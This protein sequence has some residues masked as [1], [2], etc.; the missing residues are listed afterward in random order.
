MRVRCSAALLVLML[1]GLLSAQE[2]TIGPA[3]TMGGAAR[4][5]I[6]EGDV[7]YYGQGAN[8]GVADITDRA[9]PVVL[10]FLS[11]PHEILD[12]EIR[13]P[14]AYIYLMDNG[15]FHIVDITDPSDVRI[16]GSCSVAS[17]YS[18]KL[19]VAGNRVF[20]V[21][22]RKNVHV[23]DVEQASNP[24]VT[25]SHSFLTKDVAVSGET[26]F[27]LG[28]EYGNDTPRGLYSFDVSDPLQ[29]TALDTFE[30]ETIQF[31]EINGN[32]AFV[33]EGKDFKGLKILDISD[34]TDIRHTS[35]IRVDGSHRVL[36]IGENYA[37]MGDDNIT[38]IDISDLAN[39]RVVGN[40]QFPA[41]SGSQFIDREGSYLYLALRNGI[42]PFN[43]LDISN[44]A[45]PSEIEVFNKAPQTTIQALVQG[46]RLYI[47]SAKGFW[48]YSIAEQTNP[49]LIGF[50]EHEGRERI[51]RIA[52]HNDYVY[53]AE[54]TFEGSIA[55]VYIHSIQNPAQPTLLSSFQS[56]GAIKD[57][58]VV[59]DW[60][61][62]VFDTGDVEFYSLTDPANPSLAGHTTVDGKCRTIEISGSRAFVAHTIDDTEMRVTLFDIS[63]LNSIQELGFFNTRGY[64]EC[65]QI[66]GDSVLVG[67][68]IGD[69][70]DPLF[71]LQGKR[72]ES[73]GSWSE[74]ASLQST[75]HIMAM[76]VI[77][78]YVF[79][80]IFKGSVHVY[81]MN[82]HSFEQVGYCE[83]KGTLGLATT[84]VNANGEGTAFTPEGESYY[85]FGEKFGSKGLVIQEYKM[86]KSCC[87]ETVVLPPEAA[88][89]GC[90]ATPDRV[91]G[92]CQSEVT[93]MAKEGEEW[94]FDFWSGAA[95]GSEL[96]TTARM[97]DNCSI[98]YAH[99]KQVPIL[100]LSGAQ[101]DTAFCPD[102]PELQSGV[103]IL[104]FSLTADDLA[105]WK[106]MSIQFSGRGF[107]DDAQDIKNARLYRGKNL[108]GETQ[109]AQDDG[110]ITFSLS[111]AVTIPA[112]G[113]VTL[114]LEYQFQD[115]LTFENQTIKTFTAHTQMSWI[116]AIPIVPPFE[117]FQKTPAAPLGATGGEIIIAPVW[118]LQ[119]HLGYATINKA[120]MAEQTDNGHTILACPGTYSENVV[121]NKSLTIR[122]RDGWQETRIHAK[123]PDAHTV[124]VEADSCTIDGF[125]M[126]GATKEHMAGCKFV[127]EGIQTGVIKNCM[128]TNNAIGLAI[129]DG[130]INVET[131]T[132]SE[133][134]QHGIQ[135]A[136]NL[137]DDGPVSIKSSFMIQNLGNGLEGTGEEIS[138]E[139]CVI[140]G[141]AKSGAIVTGTIAFTDCVIDSNA[142]QGI[143]GL[144][145]NH[146]PDGQVLILNKNVDIRHNGKNGIW[147][148]FEIQSSPQAVL[149]ISDN[150]EYGVNGSEPTRLNRAL[151]EN[152]KEGGVLVADE[153]IGLNIGSEDDQPVTI[154]RNNGGHGISCDGP[155]AIANTEISGH[156]GSGILCE[157]E[158]GMGCSNL[159]VFNNRYTGIMCYGHILMP[160]GSFI[161]VTDN[162]NTGIWALGS[163]L[164]RNAKIT[165]NDG[166]G[167]YSRDL[168][169]GIIIGSTPSAPRC[170]ISNNRWIGV[171]GFGP[172]TVVNARI[173]DNGSHGINCGGEQ[174]L[175]IRHCDIRN[176]QNGGILTQHGFTGVN[177]NNLIWHNGG[178]GIYSMG[179]NITAGIG[180]AGVFGELRLYNNK[181]YGM[182]IEKG[183][184]LIAGP[185]NRMMGNEKSGIYVAEGN[186]RG[187][188]I[189]SAGNHEHGIHVAGS[190]LLLGSVL[191]HNKG[192]GLYAGGETNLR[193][194]NIYG[195]ELGGIQIYG[196]ETPGDK[197]W[198]SPLLKTTN[199]PLKTL[200]HQFLNL[201][202]DS[203]GPVG[204]EQFD[205]LPLTIKESNVTNHTSYGLHS[206]NSPV[207][208]TD[209]W[210]G[211][212]S[213]PSGLGSG[214]GDAINGSIRFD[215]WA[216]QAYGVAVQAMQDTFMLAAGQVDTLDL[217]VQSW[218]VISDQISVTVSDSLGWSVLPVRNTITTTDTTSGYLRIHIDVPAQSSSAVNKI[219]VTA[220]S[221]QNPESMDDLSFYVLPY[222]GELFA[223][224]VLPE[225]AKIRAGSSLTFQAMGYDS[226]GR[227]VT[228]TVQWY[229]LSGSI[230]D[231]GVYSAPQ[232]TG[233]DTVLVQTADQ[234]LQK[235]VVVEILP[236][237]ASLEIDPAHMTIETGGTGTF[238][239]RAVNEQGKETACYPLW[240]A[241]SGQINAKGLY[242][243]GQD[244][245]T[246]QITVQDSLGGPAAT[247]TVRI[248]LPT[249]VDDQNFGIVDFALEQNYPNPF[250]PVTT[251]GFRVAK[252]E[253]VRLRIFDIRGRLVTTLVDEQQGIG[254]YTIPFDAGSLASGVYFYSIQ[255]GE[256]ND[257]KKLILLK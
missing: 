120:I 18:G 157:S 184:V 123:T 14:Y 15:G 84:Q 128:F 148:D 107:G 252:D 240:S 212:A 229:A 23:I 5:V 193:G 162:N 177:H 209:V 121:V 210:W 186:L 139:N 22:D 207:I 99:F 34:P 217:S 220:H 53:E 129:F 199:S 153:T 2:V 39:P 76:D 95:S 37:A 166:H 127:G 10:S 163:L 110:R 234:Q 191:I 244:T 25:Y 51:K 185:N 109:F 151:I 119:T 245:G 160:E 178:D 56:R 124:K 20:V 7:A 236:A 138:L 63:N 130:S 221:L 158:E 170:D 58:K 137:V 64:P 165:N 16:L 27:V 68:N 189:T 196:E 145:F 66:M 21:E 142:E 89:E 256:F 188:N 75:G 140:K 45:V 48:I 134:T 181:G 70:D 102:A 205:N 42:Q 3:G 219:T 144:A 19:D 35:N 243:A 57:I 208:A 79:A 17:E 156:P 239:V 71:H 222:S 26:L 24:T 250:N 242:T 78:G 230:D 174:G 29:W 77:E 43:I 213:G 126:A 171:F 194:V 201:N 90:S 98:A 103:Q 172:V 122:S 73:D 218:L 13:Y 152:N 254:H 136:E 31:L 149:N 101:G 44:P 30:L 108:L 253:H 80:G 104:P 238:T 8:F 33:R 147:S 87:L 1:L 12:M 248:T 91:S 28:G 97:T 59:N 60:L 82:S 150:G 255:M 235:Q 88:D 100:A 116:N 190:T 202:I 226:L 159:K 164:L 198:N 93:V 135:V 11:I 92:E 125:L 74:F 233:L 257:V 195:N 197:D 52:V 200:A 81:K 117:E 143:R 192:Y 113:T 167:V 69:N 86:S 115:S 114:R 133:N 182:N 67:S 228:P 237:I 246:V 50:K 118:N 54:D 132:A 173:H 47:T 146:D 176:N 61:V 46:D 9:H 227:A 214:S 247:A 62:M 96:T 231:K 36:H 141:N 32:H 168:A 249:H 225:Q 211:E 241:T 105:E 49:Q 111:P 216:Q 131:V 180:S 206:P 223:L 155:I 224:D 203:N 106:C 55:T 4:A 161:E 179:T 85:K 169:N 112:G 187:Y 232:E 154:I 41:N 175:L 83:S 183:N 6:V 40:Y 65:I 251:I 38:L 94:I 215:P 204:I 72:L